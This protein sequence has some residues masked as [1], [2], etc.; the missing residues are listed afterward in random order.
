MFPVD[1]I[2]TRLQLNG[3]QCC[4]PTQWSERP[5]FRGLSS[6]LLGQVPNGMLVYGSYEVYKRELTEKFPSLTATQARSPMLGDVTGSIW[7]APFE[8][9]KQR[10][11]AGLYSG[12]RQGIRSTV[13]DKGIFGLYTGYKA[14]VLRDMSFHAIQLPLY[15][16]IKDFWLRKISRPS[17]G[18]Q[19]SWKNAARKLQPWES[20]TVGAIAGAT[21]GALTTP[22][23]VLKTRLMASS[24]MSASIGNGHLHRT[25]VPSQF[26]FLCLLYLSPFSVCYTSLLSLSPIPLSSLDS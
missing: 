16:A 21:S 6:S 13:A 24:P 10:V 17:S 5:L 7:L 3:A 1:T 8:R 9:T 4:T 23:D 22:I 12:M 19:G 18:D 2:K 26:S 15:E 20:M 25:D 11:Q 14:Q